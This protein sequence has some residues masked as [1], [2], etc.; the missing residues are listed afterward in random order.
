[1]RKVVMKK[2]NV[3][4]EGAEQNKGLSDEQQNILRDIH[5]LVDIIVIEATNKE[6]AMLRLGRVLGKF[7]DTL[8]TDRKAK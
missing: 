4:E 7:L 1:M 6:R 8:P 2:K 3:K 5:G